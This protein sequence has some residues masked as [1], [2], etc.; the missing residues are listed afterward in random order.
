MATASN[1]NASKTAPAPAPAP[2]PAALP[3]PSQGGSYT[4]QP[5]GS[6]LPDAP[7]A[8]QKED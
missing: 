3:M 6:L 7:V 8:P 2:A 4:R 1:K 5:D